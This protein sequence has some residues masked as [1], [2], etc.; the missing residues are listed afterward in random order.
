MRVTTGEVYRVLTGGADEVT[1][2]GSALGY[3]AYEFFCLCG[4]THN[5]VTMLR[6]G[7]STCQ[8]A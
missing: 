5:H 4:Y 1:G 6:Q 7:R 8:C 2:V 3:T